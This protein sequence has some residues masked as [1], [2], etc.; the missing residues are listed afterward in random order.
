[1]NWEVEFTDEFGVWWESLTEDEQD[2]VD[3]G[4]KAA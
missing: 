2:S 3:V 4:G 1:M